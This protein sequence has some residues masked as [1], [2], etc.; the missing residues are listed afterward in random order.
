MLPHLIPVTSQ[1]PSTMQPYHVE[2]VEQLDSN[3]N[4]ALSSA[5][6]RISVPIQVNAFSALGAQIAHPEKI[7]GV[8]N[9]EVDLTT[10]S[11]SHNHV[12]FADEQN[13]D[14]IYEY[15]GDGEVEEH[16]GKKLEEDDDDVVILED[17]E[18]G[19]PGK[20][21][22]VVID[23]LDEDNYEN[24]RSNELEEEY[25]SDEE[26]DL[27]YWKNALSSSLIMEEVE[28]GG[29]EEQRL[30]EDI[31]VIPVNFVN[32]QEEQRRSPSVDEVM[33]QPI[34]LSTV[35]SQSSYNCS[36]P[37]SELPSQLK[38]PLLSFQR[39]RQKLPATSIISSRIRYQ[40]KHCD[41]SYKALQ[42]LR[43][44][45][46]EHLPGGR[47]KPFLCG[48]CDKRFSNKMLLEQHERVHTG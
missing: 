2:F 19:K 15:E 1:C 5:I 42:R 13:P 33:P 44:H 39:V 12:L 3:A 20:P 18:E 40:C 25:E 27:E 43:Y 48:L 32:V 11:S 47:P 45:E 9:E 34:A 35:T 10:S 31:E 23:V 28:E 24:D 26:M 46:Q 6:G 29:D 17:D 38:K 36:S 22:A 30:E 21:T 7:D 8:L 41:K 14:V 4:G 37:S 16:Q